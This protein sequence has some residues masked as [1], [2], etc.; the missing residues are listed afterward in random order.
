MNL[1]VI[2][3]KQTATQARPRIP[4]QF[5]LTPYLALP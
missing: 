3:L 4:V 5:Y 2:G 1:I